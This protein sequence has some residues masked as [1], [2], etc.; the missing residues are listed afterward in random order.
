MISKWIEIN[1]H[2]WRTKMHWEKH[3]RE[4]K[5]YLHKESNTA[6]NAHCLGR[7]VQRIIP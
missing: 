2:S 6:E 1:S 3:Q 7:T 5:K 4:I